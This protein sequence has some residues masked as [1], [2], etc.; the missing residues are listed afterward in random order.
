MRRRPGRDAQLQLVADKGRRLHRTGQGNNYPASG[1]TL[2]IP[3][4]GKGF[5]PV[6]WAQDVMQSAGGDYDAVVQ[7]EFRAIIV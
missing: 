4:E 7:A 2:H 1:L 3:Q 5:D 6:E